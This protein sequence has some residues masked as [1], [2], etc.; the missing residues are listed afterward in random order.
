MSLAASCGITPQE[1]L[2]MTPRELE[3]FAAAYAE[4]R[5]AEQEGLSVIAYNTAILM[6]SVIWGRGS[7]PSYADAFPPRTGGEAAP[8]R[9]AELYAAAR[10]LNAALGG[11]EM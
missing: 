5:A 2:S 1:W 9:D 3:V 4:A 6:R 10:A 11:K 7:L 8:C